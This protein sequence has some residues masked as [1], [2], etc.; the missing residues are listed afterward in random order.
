MDSKIRLKEYISNN[1]NDLYLLID[2]LNKLEKQDILFDDKIINNR[3]IRWIIVKF[4]M[5]INRFPNK[6]E[7]IY[8]EDYIVEN[9]KTYIK[10]VCL[11]KNSNSEILININ[12]VLC[13][14]DIEK[15]CLER[16]DQHISDIN[17]NQLDNELIFNNKTFLNKKYEKIGEFIVQYDDIDINNHLNNIE[18]I[19]LLSKYIKNN[20]VKELSIDY[21]KQILL[22]QKIS[23]YESENHGKYYKYMD[24]NGSVYTTFYIN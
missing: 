14:Y 11:I 22:K 4:D 21:H 12:C 24:D 16:I 23:I 5:K 8:Y 20:K 17:I 13:L 3:S 9:R 1:Q 15:Q 19:K 18:Y 10:H 2:I 6:H 7:E